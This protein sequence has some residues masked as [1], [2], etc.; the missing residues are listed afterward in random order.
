MSNRG[1]ETIESNIE[2]EAVPA[3]QQ[4]VEEKEMASHTGTLPT[5]YLEGKYTRNPSKSKKEPLLLDASHLTET[6]IRGSGPGGQAINKLSTCV[7][8]KHAPTGLVIRCQET[9]SRE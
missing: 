4:E 5:W 1:I 8:I 6:F 7:Q 3:E 2:V 9:R